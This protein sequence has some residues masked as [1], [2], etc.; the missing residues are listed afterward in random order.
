ML[1]GVEAPPSFLRYK[2]SQTTPKCFT[3][4]TAPVLTHVIAAVRC[5]TVTLGESGTSTEEMSARGL[6][7]AV[8][9]QE[10][11]PEAALWPRS[12]HRTPSTRRQLRARKLSI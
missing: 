9:G 8:L 3:G 7:R 11:P 1:V 2:D 5:A 12:R 6:C 10:A 4:R